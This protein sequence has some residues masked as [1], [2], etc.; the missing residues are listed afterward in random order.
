LMESGELFIGAKDIDGV[1]L[2]WTRR[3]RRSRCD[4]QLSLLAREK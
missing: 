1:R 3:C 4:Q 2:R